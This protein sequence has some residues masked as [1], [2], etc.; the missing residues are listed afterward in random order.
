VIRVMSELPPGV[1]GFEARGKVTAYDYGGVMMP[2]IN[3]VVSG[4]D[5]IRIV[6]HLGPEFEGFTLGAMFDDAI[7]GVAHPGKWERAAVVSDVKWV[8]KS[9]GVFAAI[10]RIPMRLFRN[11]ELDAA[12]EWAAGKDDE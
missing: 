6:Y 2:E 10:L 8:H 9:F 3:R 1:L 12:A 7:A 11:A 5:K 4:G